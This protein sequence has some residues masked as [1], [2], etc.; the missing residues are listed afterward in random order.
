[1]PSGIPFRLVK[2]D[3]VEG[4]GDG[5]QDNRNGIP[6]GKLADP[7]AGPLGQEISHMPRNGG[8]GREA[9]GIDAE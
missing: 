3:F 8:G 2:A 7:L 5:G 9:R 1:M 6:D 4:G